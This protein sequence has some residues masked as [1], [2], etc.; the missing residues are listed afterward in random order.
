MGTQRGPVY[1][2][3]AEMMNS[4]HIIALLGIAACI[5]GFTAA[6]AHAGC[7]TGLPCITN[8]TPNDVTNPG[9]GPNNGGPNRPLV[10]TGGCNGNP[11]DRG[12]A[13]DADLMNQMYSRAWLESQRETIK[14]EVLIRKPD[15]I[16]EYTCFDR[17]VNVVVARAAP[18]FSESTRWRPANV[19]ITSEWGV[20]FI[21]DIPIPMVIMNTWM[22]PMKLQTS[23]RGLVLDSLTPY[24]NDSFSHRFLGGAATSLD[25]AASGS[26]TY[27]CSYMDQVWFLSKCT[28]IVTDDRFWK[29][30]ELIGN[31]PRVLPAACTGGTQ[32]TQAR[33]D[34]AD[35]I[36]KQ[37][38]YMDAVTPT[39]YNLT[40]PPGGP[41][42]CAPPIPTGLLVVQKTRNVD[43]LGNV[44]VT[45]T[46]TVTDMVCPNPN[47]QYTGVTCAP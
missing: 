1:D 8:F 21:D 31:D 43:A 14:M 23:L 35:N 10:A 44:T 46:N 30:S 3:G 20:G 5:V 25:Y 6:K 32:I 38:V 33:I 17:H 13:C 45:A 42:T 15:S 36:N 47:C 2:G 18:L 27:N 7:A 41:V 4:R 34:L 12:C 24:I 19:S 26:S 39:H 11:P 28:D 29:F 37:H 9:D 40:R 22:G 16:L